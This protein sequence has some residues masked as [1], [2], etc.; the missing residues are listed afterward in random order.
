MEFFS[1]NITDLPLLLY[2]LSHFCQFMAAQKHH[3]PHSK[4]LS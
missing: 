4:Q 2:L 3:W 1:A